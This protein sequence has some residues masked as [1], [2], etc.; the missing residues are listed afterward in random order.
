MIASHPCRVWAGR[1]WQGRSRFGLSLPGE[2]ASCGC[3][4]GSA[5]M[6]CIYFSCLPLF[7]GKMVA[8]D[9]PKALQ[10]T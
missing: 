10:P 6:S 7:A 5:D 2:C 9:V 4:L 3:Y 8:I 1:G